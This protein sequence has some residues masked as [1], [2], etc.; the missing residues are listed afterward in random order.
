MEGKETIRISHISKY[1]GNATM[2]DW[3]VFLVLIA[4]CH[5][6]RPI[7]IKMKN[8]PDFNRLQNMI[9]NTGELCNGIHHPTIFSVLKLGPEDFV[10]KDNLWFYYEETLLEEPKS[11]KTPVNISSPTIEYHYKPKTGAQKAAEYID[12]MKKKSPY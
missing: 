3:P 9:H 11:K 6:S 5:A 8:M 1:D 7:Y 4:S 12:R 2:K 10:P